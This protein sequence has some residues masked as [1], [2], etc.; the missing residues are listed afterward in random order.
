MYLPPFQCIPRSSR[1]MRHVTSAHTRSTQ[2]QRTAWRAVAT[3]VAHAWSQVAL[4]MRSTK[5]PQGCGYR[6]S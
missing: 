5:A 4:A 1:G 6:C 2:G 3:A